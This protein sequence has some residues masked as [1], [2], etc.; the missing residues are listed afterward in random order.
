MRN[1]GASSALRTLACFDLGHGGGA[2][3]HKPWA[4]LCCYVSGG[5]QTAP[6]AHNA[7]HSRTC[8]VVLAPWQWV[9]CD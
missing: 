1:A 8:S 2:W 5:K 3:L 4:C 7:A 6:G 9:R